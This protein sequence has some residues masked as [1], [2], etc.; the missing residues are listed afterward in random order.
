MAGLSS[1]VYDV[2]L[3]PFFFFVNTVSIAWE[4]TPRGKIE[5]SLSFDTSSQINL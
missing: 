5:K 1:R 2:A 4:H 3:S